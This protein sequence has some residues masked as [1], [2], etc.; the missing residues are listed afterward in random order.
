MLIQDQIKAPWTG[1]VRGRVW[2]VD[3]CDVTN[4][5]QTIRN[6]ESSFSKTK[7]SSELSFELVDT[8]IL[9]VHQTKGDLSI[10]RGC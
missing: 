2:S 8:T 5:K 1:E 6:S 4:L 3:G 7:R 9:V 10:P